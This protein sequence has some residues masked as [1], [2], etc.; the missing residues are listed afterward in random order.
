MKTPAKTFLTFVETVVI[1]TERA[2]GFSGS[3]IVMK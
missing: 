3:A 1:F 2:Q